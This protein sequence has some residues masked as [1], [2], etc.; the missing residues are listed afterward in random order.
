MNEKLNN[1]SSWE[2]KTSGQGDSKA[3]LAIE[4]CHSCLLTYILTGIPPHQPKL[5]GESVSALSLLPRLNGTN[6]GSCG[7]S[8]D[9]ELHTLGK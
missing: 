8:L 1:L 9:S 3:R 5:H 7:F 4:P 6:V 2:R